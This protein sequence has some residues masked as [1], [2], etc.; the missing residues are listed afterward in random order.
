MDKPS[1]KPVPLDYAPP[2]TRTV[3]RFRIGV[4][5]LCMSALPLLIAAT[6]M[7]EFDCGRINSTVYGSFVDKAM[8]LSCIGLAIGFMGLF[9][10][11][12]RRAAIASIIICFLETILLP[13]LEIAT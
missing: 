4:I 2:D 1:K 3:I 11:N 13:A 7:L 5:A 12:G 6:G 8:K 9:Q 10:R